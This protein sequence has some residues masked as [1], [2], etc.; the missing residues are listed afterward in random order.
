MKKKIN[1]RQR[2]CINN[3]FSPKTI[4][5]SLRVLENN[6]SQITEMLDRKDN[7]LEWANKRCVFKKL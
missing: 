6:L 5:T 3:N 7:P 2:S 1:W 4:R